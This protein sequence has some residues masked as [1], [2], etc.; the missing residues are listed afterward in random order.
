MSTSSTSAETTAEPQLSDAER[1]ELEQIAAEMPNV[2]A[3]CVRTAKE[4]MDL[5]LKPDQQGVAKLDTMIETAWQEQSPVMVDHLTFLFMAFL[6]EAVKTE[7]PGTQWAVHEDSGQIALKTASGK[8]GFPLGTVQ[9]KLAGEPASL[10]FFLQ[11]FKHQ[12]A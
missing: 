6:G 2:A 11:A 10:A 8:W 7:V 5:D 3:L 9:S 4:V 12:N 1:Q